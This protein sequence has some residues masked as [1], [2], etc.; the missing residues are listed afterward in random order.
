MFDNTLQMSCV[1]LQA[2]STCCI[3]V[4]IL[5]NNPVNSTVPLSFRIF[6]NKVADADCC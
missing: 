5:L 3:A 4:R 1:Y 6:I 2:P